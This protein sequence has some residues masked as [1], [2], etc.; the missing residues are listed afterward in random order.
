M[1]TTTYTVDIFEECSNLVTQE[2]ITINVVPNPIAGTAT[3]LPAT[4]CEGQTSTISLVGYDGG[5]QWQSAPGAGGPWTNIPGAIN[6]IYNTGPI[7][8]DI[9][10]R[11]EVGGCG[12]S[13]FSNIVCVTMAPLPV[14]TVSNETICEG[15][16][17][18]LTTN[19]DL[20]GGTY[21]WN[22]SGQNGPDLANVSPNVTTV[23]DVT[24]D[25]N[26]CVITESGTVTVLPQPTT[27][28]L[29]DQIICSGD[30]ATFTANPD[31]PGGDYLWAPGGQVTNAITVSPA[32]GNYTY[33]LTYN[34]GGCEVIEDVDLTVNQTPQVAI[35]NEEICLGENMTMTAVPDIA[36]GNYVWGPGGE[37]TNSIN[38]SPAATTNYDV[39]YTLNGCVA[40]ANATLT[41]HPIPVA[42][43]NFD[44][45][46]EDNLTTLT[47]TSNVNAPSIIQD[48]EWDI[49][50]NGTVDYTNPNET[51]DF[52]GWGTYP[53]SLTVTTDAGCTASV[54]E[55]VEVYPLPNID[56]TAT[57]LCL[58]SPTDFNDLTV[59]PNG[60]FITDWTWD[61][62]DGNGDNIQNPSHTYAAPAVYP[63]NLAVVTNNG[64]A[65]NITSDVE[66]YSMPVANFAVDNECF[67]DAF[68]FTN[69]SAGNATIFNWDFGDGNNSNQE[70]PNH[71]Y[72][73]AGQYNV[74]FNISTVDGCGDEIIIPVTAYAQPNAEFSVDP[75]C[76]ETNSAF[77]D[78]SVVNAV[79]GDAIN[80]WQWNFGDGNNSNQQNPNHLYGNE[81][82]YNVSLTVTTNYGCVDTYNGQ[83]TVW[84]LPDVNF[85]PT[86]VCL[87]TPTVFNDLSTISNTYSANNNAQWDWDFGDGGNSNQQNP[88]YTYNSDGQYNTTLIVTSNNGCSN[89]N[90]LVVTVH[91]KPVVNFTG[92]NLSGCSPVCF[93]L[94]S[95]SV[96]NNPSTIVDY[97][98]TL[99]NGVTYNSTDPSVSDCFVNNTS[100]SIFIGVELTATSNLGCSN[101]H[102]EPS[103]I[104]IYHN[105]IA[106]FTFTPEKPDVYD[107]TVTFI[108]S[109]LYADN[110]N[111]NI[112]GYGTSN[113]HSPVADFPL[114]PETYDVELITTTDEGC[115]D[116][117]YAV[118]DVLDRIIFYV[119]NTFTP[120]YDDY[121]QFFTPIFTS[122]F[123]PYDFNLLIFNRFG[124]I[125][126]ESNDASIG[127]DGTYGVESNEFVKDGTYVWKIEFKETM[128]DK[129]HVHTGHVNLLR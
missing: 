23:Y 92:E 124:E 2:N 20:T 74:T 96:V 18:T 36:G 84:P 101:S 41:V 70:N 3:A 81:N 19:V 64:C 42:S 52:N 128:T 56:F 13:V 61:F 51:H 104:E 10:F 55:V 90:T 15:E 62:A 32:A 99:S 14:L 77:V 127:W 107:A 106:S 45:V 115:S 25:L 80:Q 93:T 67:Y 26:G 1:V 22:P 87:E 71:T 100:N 63:V 46:C 35:A 39:T 17:T 16:T 108:N 29:V 12:P 109:S 120:D 28:N 98:W 21:A 119:P 79:D 47:S 121:N 11:A 105:P 66:I 125:I 68:N 76:L 38:V 24:Y 117:A 37:V 49:L 5:I 8:N 116:T 122:G 6:D 88:N 112:S 59:V 82:V 33:T 43:F 48:Y 102:F 103:F 73:A 27:L 50:E 86:D 65:G 85:S 40:T 78:E 31:V 30:N 60:G 75:T 123:D 58:G 57:P 97:T 95:T 53:V 126:F 54:S 91:P 89:Q 83:A 34:V 110:Y 114:V 7:N 44:N 9:C 111:W 69:Q 113:D 72:A 4:V 94:N 129:R 118:V